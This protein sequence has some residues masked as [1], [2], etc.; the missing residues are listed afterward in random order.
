V[1]ARVGGL[2]GGGRV[3]AEKH[4]QISKFDGINGIFGEGFDR[5]NEIYGIGETG[6]L[7][8]RAMGW[9]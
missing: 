1:E 7:V 9:L 2:Y 8:L 4:D 6:N 5:I 3:T